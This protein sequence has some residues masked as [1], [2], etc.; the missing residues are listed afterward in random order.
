MASDVDWESE[1]AVG[2]QEGSP[3]AS[4]GLDDTLWCEIA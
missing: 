4:D 3:G 2:L 1:Q